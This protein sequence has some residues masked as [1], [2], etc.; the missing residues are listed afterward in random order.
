MTGRFDRQIAT[1]KRLI[2][3]NGQKVTWR[4]MTDGAPADENKPWKAGVGSYEEHEVFICFLPEDLRNKEFIRYLTGM[5]VTT[6][7]IIGLLGNVPFNPSPKDV[8]IRDGVEYR[9]ND[10]ELLS[11]NGQKV[12]YTV[13]FKG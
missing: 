1:A 4:V 6:G 12:L 10:I 11:P 7:T 2:Q 13:E 8:V 9:I 3:K 5:E